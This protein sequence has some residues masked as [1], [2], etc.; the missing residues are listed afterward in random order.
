MNYSV[1]QSKIAIG[2]AGLWGK[3]YGQGSQTQLGFLPEPANDFIFS[4]FVE[5]WGWVFGI[6]L[7]AAFFAL[8]ASILKVGYRAERNVEKLI[9]LGAAILFAWQFFLNIGS[10]TGMFPVVGVTFPFVSYG[11]SSLLTSLFLLAIIHAIEVRS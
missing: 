9:C 7:I 8:I 11:G 4:A 6:A 2:S 10:A 5:E 1:A 3:G